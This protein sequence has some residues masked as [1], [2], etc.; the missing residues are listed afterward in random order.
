MAKDRSRASGKNEGSFAV[1]AM[2]LL[3]QAYLDPER[4]NWADQVV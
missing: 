3:D 4:Q 1:W 2:D